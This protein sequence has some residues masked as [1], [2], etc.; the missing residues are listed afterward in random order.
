MAINFDSPKTTT[1]RGIA[2]TGTIP[3]YGNGYLS[4]SLHVTG[5]G[6]D[7]TF[8]RVIPLVNSTSTPSPLSKTYNVAIIPKLHG[9]DTVTATYGLSFL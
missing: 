1:V 5:T 9:V 7:D 4:I 8:K 3:K 2:V 6:K